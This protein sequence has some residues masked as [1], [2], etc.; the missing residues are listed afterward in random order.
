MTPPA[1]FTRAFLAEPDLTAVVRLVDALAVLVRPDDQLCASCAWERIVKPLLRPLVGWERGAPRQAPNPAPGSSWAPVDLAEVL[2]SADA[3]RSA[4]LSTEDV[5]RQ[6]AAE[7]E[8][9]TERWLRT[10]AA[11][12][13]V[14]GELLARLAAIDPGNG[15]GIGAGPELGA[16]GQTDRRAAWIAAE[17]VRLSSSSYHCAHGLLGKRPSWPC[18]CVDHD[19][20]LDHA[21]LWVRDGRPAVLLAHTY[22]GAADAARQAQAYAEAHGLVV[23]VGRREDAWYG[24]GTVPVRFELAADHA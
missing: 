18:S 2:P 13:A 24:F 22:L 23:T 9:D 7:A 16:E 8:T 11:W 5:K 20:L 6:A 4:L 17:G 15:H 14:A 21:R 10:S 3:I 19:R 12:D 1:D